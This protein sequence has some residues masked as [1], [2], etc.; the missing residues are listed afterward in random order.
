MRDIVLKKRLGDGRLVEVEVQ[1][2]AIGRY[3]CLVY[4]AGKWVD[5]PEQPLP[6]PMPR[7]GF[8]HYLGGRAAGPVVGLTGA[9]ATEISA[10]LLRRKSA[11]DG[12]TNQ[13][14]I[15]KEGSYRSL[16]PSI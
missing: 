2:Y 8:T 7:A 13:N 11:A 16:H 12:V 5:G 6:L 3:R 9:E 1:E 10:E 14:G 4:V 15:R